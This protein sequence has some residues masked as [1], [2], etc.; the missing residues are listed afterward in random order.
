MEI[1]N[2]EIGMVVITV[3]ARGRVKKL[4][5]SLTYKGVALRNPR[6]FAPKPFP[7]LVVSP[8]RRFLS[9]RFPPSRFAPLVVSPTFHCK[10]NFHC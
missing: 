9:G 3:V 6:R 4:L 7:P 8:P 10:T 5:K 1:T 2:V